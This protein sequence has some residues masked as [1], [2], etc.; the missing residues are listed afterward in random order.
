[1][2]IFDKVQK[3]SNNG[4]DAIE[5][6]HSENLNS[7]LMFTTLLNYVKEH[8]M[9]ITAGSDYHG[10]LHSG[11]RI[12]KLKERTETGKYESKIYKYII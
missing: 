7:N 3:L 9:Y 6:F 1:M 2:N 5:V 12:S 8:N 10:S 4:I 11:K